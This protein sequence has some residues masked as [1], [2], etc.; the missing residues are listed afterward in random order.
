MSENVDK[1]LR[2]GYETAYI[3]GA[4]AAG[5]AYKPSFVS[6]NPSE[7]R[8]VISTIEDELLKCNRKWI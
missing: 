6:N 1:L 2:A 5:V 8:K 7:G 4:L 3:N